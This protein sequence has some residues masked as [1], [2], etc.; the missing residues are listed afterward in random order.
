[1]NQIFRRNVI[2]G[3]LSD[4]LCYPSRGWIRSDS[5]MFDFPS[6]M[7]DDDED[8]Q[9]LKIQS[10]N[11]KEIHGP[12]TLSMIVKKGFPRLDL[13]S[14]WGLR[15]LLDIFRDG[16]GGRSI[17]NTKVNQS[18]MNLL[19]RKE[20]VFPMNSFDQGYGCARDF[21]PASFSGFSFP[22]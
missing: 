12:D 16:V 1:M 17:S 2:G 21:W 11:N 22:E 18:L 13:F 8:I 20:R 9:Y 10:G 6:V 14:A 4:L 15:R 5:K 19:R 7:A 3:G